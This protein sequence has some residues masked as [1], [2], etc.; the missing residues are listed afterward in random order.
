MTLPDFV[1]YNIRRKSVI[2]EVIDDTVVDLGRYA[3]LIEEKLRSGQLTGALMEGT[4][5]GAPGYPVWCTTD[6]YSTES[7]ADRVRNDLG[8]FHMTGGY[9]VEVKYPTDLSGSLRAPTFLDACSRS[10]DNW[11][12][13]K[14]RD[15]GGPDW[16]YTAAMKPG[17]VFAKGTPE[18]VHPAIRISTAQGSNFTIRVL[19][20]LMA[21]PPGIVFGA[22]LASPSL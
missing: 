14:N 2:V 22:A 3:I 16:G 4:F 11:I 15:P 9:I 8:L 7:D 6:V 5:L 12:F 20:P 21:S 1:L 13:V 10:A 19:G 18:A 17:G